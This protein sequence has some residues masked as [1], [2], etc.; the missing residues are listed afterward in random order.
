MD[1][2]FRKLPLTCTPGLSAEQRDS[3]ILNGNYVLNKND[4]SKSIRYEKRDIHP[5]LA[6]N[7]C[8]YSMNIENRF[9]VFELKRYK[10]RI[11]K[12][13]VVF[14][15]CGGSFVSYSQQEFKIYRLKHDTLIE[16]I[17]QTILP[18]APDIADFLKKE[19]PDSIKAMIVQSTNLCF[20]QEGE[21][22]FR[23]YTKKNN[24]ELS[25]TW[26]T[27]LEIGFLWN[28]SSF[29][30]KKNNDLNN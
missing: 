4:P 14:T 8:K 17:E 24:D 30:R 13:L 1:V 12:D 9:Y 27:T 28:G 5:E 23:I 10:K 11:G 18:E 2:V 20:D 29:R 16:D 25:N 7:Y 3:L 22:T 6:D 26:R 21:L 19:T 15:A